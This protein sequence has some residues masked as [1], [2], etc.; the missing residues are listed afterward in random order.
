MPYDSGR[1]PIDKER[2]LLSF[3][4]RPIAIEAASSHGPL[5]GIMAGIDADNDGYVSGPHEQAVLF[6]RLDAVDGVQDGW[7]ND[8]EPVAQNM[9]AVLDEVAAAFAGDLSKA[10]TP[11]SNIGGAPTNVR[12]PPGLRTIG[13]GP[14]SAVVQPK[15]RTWSESEALD[16]LRSIVAAALVARLKSGGLGP[17]AR[18][19]LELRLLH[20]HQHRPASLVLDELQGQLFDVDGALRTEVP[21]VAL[22]EVITGSAPDARARQRL[23]M[24]ET[25]QLGDQDRAWIVADV[26]R[27]SGVAT[28]EKVRQQLAVQQVAALLGASEHWLDVKPDAA[29]REAIRLGRI[30]GAYLS[31][32]TRAYMHLLAA[33][34]AANAGQYGDAVAQVEAILAAPEVST[35]ILRQAWS[36]RIA[37]HTGPGGVLERLQQAHFEKLVHESLQI[38][39]TARDGTYVAP[40]FFNAGS[41]VSGQSSDPPPDEPFGPKIRSLEAEV[42]VLQDELRKAELPD[43]DRFL[44][45][46]Q[47]QAAAGQSPVDALIAARNDLPP[48]DKRNQLTLAVA[49]AM[50]QDGDHAAATAFLSEA[51]KTDE[52]TGTVRR[53]A[54]LLAVSA[55]DGAGHTQEASKVLNTLVAQ[56]EARVRNG[57]A[58]EQDRRILADAYISRGKRYLRSG[59]SVKLAQGQFEKALPLTNDAHHAATIQLELGVI[60]YRDQRPADARR[61]FEQAQTTSPRVAA[62]LERKYGELL[63][64]ADPGDLDRLAAAAEA[65]L[66]LSGSNSPSVSIG[67]AVVGAGIGAVFGGPPGMLIGLGI[68]TLI[69]RTIGVA[70]N[71]DRIAQAYQTGATTFSGQTKALA[72]IAL[73]FDLVDVVP[74]GVFLKT[75]GQALR[76]GLKQGVNA[77][78][79]SAEQLATRWNR[80]NGAQLTFTVGVAVG[81]DTIALSDDVSRYLSGDLTYDE[82]V[83]EAKRHGGNVAK[84]LATMALFAGLMRGTTRMLS[85]VT[86]SAAELPG[87][88]SLADFVL[89]KYGENDHSANLGFVKV[90]SDM[91]GNPRF[92]SDHGQQHVLDIVAKAD[93]VIHRQINYRDGVYGSRA[94]FRR[95]M[96]KAQAYLHD[97]GM[98]NPAMR[99]IHPELATQ[100]ALSTE[101]DTVFTRLWADGASPTASHLIKHF[102]GDAG[103]AQLVMREMLAMSNAHSKSRV[104]RTLLE[105]GQSDGFGEL[106]RAAALKHPDYLLLEAKL[107]KMRK[108]VARGKAHPDEL[109]PLED[110]LARYDRTFAAGETSNADLNVFNQ[111]AL[112]FYRERGLDPLQDSF[113]W[114]K[115]LE[116]TADGRNLYVDV[117]RIAQALS[118]GDALRQRGDA[119]RTSGLHQIIMNPRTGRGVVVLEDRER[120]LVRYLDTEDIFKFGESNI[121]GTRLEGENFDL[122]VDLRRGV[123]TGDDVTQRAIHTTA[124]TIDDIVS[125][126]MIFGHGQKLVVVVPPSSD[127]VKARAFGEA[128]TKNVRDRF[129]DDLVEIKVAEGPTPMRVSASEQSR[130]VEASPLSDVSGLVADIRGRPE[131]GLSV[132]KP[133]RLEAGLK[134]ARIVTLSKGQSLIKAG[135]SPEYVYLPLDAGLRINASGVRGRTFDASPYN[136]LGEVSVIGETWRNADIVASRDGIRVVAIAKSDYVDHLF[137]LADASTTAEQLGRLYRE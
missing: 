73:G 105:P 106:M 43:R 15:G 32:D 10:P 97:V 93:D 118:V 27:H 69:D 30:H 71:T 2:F 121:A 55:L 26:M 12:R 13:V 37:L 59:A 67:L 85:R 6:A 3:Q 51:L 129:G 90:A 103:R 4:N 35:S 92:Y 126:V 133:E 56:L 115:G 44:L 41:P 1:M 33:Q 60:A 117:I 125:D 79:E 31:A 22:I 76:Q 8:A 70:S 63:D 36:L 11:T 7:I 52:L 42:G 58:S 40:A 94:Q 91:T 128:V 135:T 47:F 50:L 34:A 132:V 75:G 113:T 108:A 48:S 21:L 18:A 9:L 111:E 54:R 110:Q 116:T 81:P 78:L 28:F 107:K 96:T 65:V 19:D 72:F 14:P 98:S 137:H 109:R 86:P 66:V 120:G 88:Q 5:E 24:L 89:P 23:Q 61:W 123:Y 134:N 83:D 119:L 77:G 127:P 45:L 95:D 112:Q 46:A 87:Q 57:Q 101:F 130:F 38:P 29:Y 136:L 82:L 25:Q 17:E 49:V 64:P 84:N 104:P 122:V 62:E 39:P 53:A 99:S 80:I 20:Y 124:A 102:D 114:L 131:S 74:V 16:E 100:L 68:A